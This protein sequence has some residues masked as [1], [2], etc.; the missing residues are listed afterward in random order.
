[1]GEPTIKRASFFFDGQNLFYAVKQSFGHNYPNYDVK[2]LA[3]A[4][5]K[6]KQWELSEI[7]FYTGVPDKK[8]KPFWQ[9]F[10]AKKIAVMGTQRIKTFSRKLQYSNVSDNSS[11]PILVGREKGIDIRIALDVTRKAIENDY[12]VAVIFSQDQDL[13]EVAKEIRYIAKKE[14]RWIKIASVFPVSPTYENK[15]GINNTDWIEI[16]RKLYDGCVD[17][18]D[19]RPKDAGEK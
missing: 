4:I 3:E 14:R 6:L 11:K 5:C 10:W 19:Y 17:P 13:S 9:Q 2:K 8:V 7:H 1:M 18:N 15:R 12:D 16:D